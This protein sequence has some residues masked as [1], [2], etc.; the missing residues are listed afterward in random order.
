M[1]SDMSMRTMFF[2]EPYWF[3]ANTRTNS[4]LPTP[5]GPRNMKVPMGA[6]SSR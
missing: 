2:S 5:V 6:F 3:L 1:Y 4:V